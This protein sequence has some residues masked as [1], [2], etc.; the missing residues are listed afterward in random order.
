MKI[1]NKWKTWSVIMAYEEE[2]NQRR[3][4]SQKCEISKPVIASYRKPKNEK[5]RNR[6]EI[7]ESSCMKEK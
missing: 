4:E 6:I 5:W 7:G 3:N 2:R 1:S